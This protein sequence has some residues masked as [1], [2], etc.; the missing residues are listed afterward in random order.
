MTMLKALALRVV[1]VKRKILYARQLPL[2]GAVRG[3]SQKRAFL[4]QL[5]RGL[6]EHHAKRS[7][8]EREKKPQTDSKL[9]HEKPLSVVASTDEDT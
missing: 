8:T 3:V 1:P 9:T 2:I 6:S 4:R 5:T 7:T